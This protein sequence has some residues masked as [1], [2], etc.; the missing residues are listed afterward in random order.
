MARQMI[1]PRFGHAEHRRGAYRCVLENGTTVEEMLDPMFF[2]NITGLRPGDVIEAVKEDLSGMALLLVRSADKRA[3]KVGLVTISNF[4]DQERDELPADDFRLEFNV[5]DKHRV[6]RVSDGVVLEKD[7]ATEAAAKRW[8]TNHR[9][10][11]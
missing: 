3:V 2:M 5:Q 7:L 1:N 10:T 11:L 6:V 9:K 4:E 8:L